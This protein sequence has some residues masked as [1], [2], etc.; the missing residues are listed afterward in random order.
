MPVSEFSKKT[1]PLIALMS[2]AWLPVQAESNAFKAISDAATLREV[3]T[4]TTPDAESGKDKAT[5]DG[6][7]LEIAPAELIAAVTP[8]A[9]SESNPDGV[10]VVA[11]T[12]VLL[13]GKGSAA[14]TLRTDGIGDLFGIGN[15]A[16]TFSNITFAGSGTG[17]DDADGRLAILA[18]AAVTVNGDTF[19]ADR[20]FSANEKTSNAASGGIFYSSNNFDLITLDASAGAISFSD[21]V[22][23]GDTLSITNAENGTTQ[24][25]K[26]AAAGGAIFLSG[27]LKVQGGNAVNFSG[28]SAES[29]D[30]NAFGGAVYVTSSETKKEDFGVFIGAGSQVN[31][32]DNRVLGESA[33]GGALILASGALKAEGSTLSFSGNVATA[34]TGAALGGAWVIADGSQARSDAATQ[35]SFKGN[36]VNTAGVCTLAAGGAVYLDNAT[37]KASA[38]S[39]SFENNGAQ[40]TADGTSAY[41]GALAVA[42]DSA[43]AEF[44]GDSASVFKFTGNSVSASGKSREKEVED[45]G[46]TSIVN[47]VPEALGG[48]LA[49]TGGK[50][51]FSELG[52][53]EFTRNTATVSV[54]ETRA[55][56]GAIY[57]GG[58]KS[59]L[60]FSATG[61]GTFSENAVNADGAGTAQGGALAQT[62]GTLK[63]TLSADWNFSGNSA[64]GIGST[65]YPVS[66]AGGAIAQLG[67][68]Q[69]YTATGDARLVFSA[70]AAEASS[71]TT[72][73]FALGGAI[74][75]L[76]KNAKWETSTAVTFSGNR[77]SVSQT[78]SSTVAEKASLAAGGAI[79]AMGSF[80]LADAVLTD[81]AAASAGGNG[82]AHGGAV[83]LS[84]ASFS[85]GNLSFENNAATATNAAGSAPLGSAR[86]GALYISS[87]T[88]TTQSLQF[89]NNN[90]NGEIARGGAAYVAGVLSVRKD[91][92]FSGNAVNGTAE[93][94]GGALFLTGSLKIAGEANF[95]GNAVTATGDDAL[96][97]GGAICASG[98]AEITGTQTTLSGNTVRA[99]AGTALGGAV[100]LKGGSL[101]L[102]N[103]TL[104]GNAATGAT[105]AGGAIYIDASGSATTLTLSGNTEIVGN[106][107][108]EAPDGITVGNGTAPEGSV[109]QNV[110]IKIAPGATFS[111]SVDAEGNTVTTRET[112]ETVKL[113][114]PLRVTLKGADFTLEKTE[115]GGD[116]IWSGEN[117]VTVETVSQ[118]SSEIGGKF[119]LAFRSGTTTLADGFMLTG[120]RAS[121]VDI[122]AGAEL[123]VES[124]A[125][126]CDFRSMNL[127][128]RLAVAGTLNLSD[129]EI[130][131]GTAG[132]F[133][134]EDGSASSVVGKNTVAGELTT[135]G[136]V[137]FTAN[138]PTGASLSMVSL[139]LEKSGNVSFS[140]GKESAPF[141]VTAGEIYFAE[142]GTLTLAEG[143]RLLLNAL[144]A[145]NPETSLS[146]AV[147]GSGTLVLLDK[148]D[149]NDTIAFNAY[150]DA[151]N[152]KVVA[153]QFSV[154]PEIKIEG[155]IFIA[156]GTSLDLGGLSY[157]NVVIDAGTLSASGTSADNPLVLKTISITSSAT[158][159]D[160]ESEQFIRLA[161]SVDDEGVA[162]PQKI[163]LKGDLKILAGTTLD[164]SVSLQNY[165]SANLSGEGT[166]Q[167][168]VSGPG[169]ISIARI[170][171]NVSVGATD[172]TTFSGTS[173][174]AGD[175]SNA[176]RL[177]LSQGAYLSAAGS[178]RNE[179]AGQI[180]FEGE[181]RFTGDITNAGK[182]T[183]TGNSVLESGSRF[184]QTDAGTLVV[185]PGASLD[186]SKI[187]S[188]AGALSLDGTLVITP[189]NYAIGEEFSALIGLK[190]GQLDA[191]EITDTASNSITDRIAWNDALDAYVFLGLNGRKI[192]TTLYGDL[193]RENIFRLYDFMRAGL[194]HGKTASIRPS[195]FG[196]DKKI[197]RY[198]RNYLE[199]KNRFNTADDKP[200]L[201]AVE[202]SSTGEA[203]RTANALMNNV[204]VQA[205]YGR[206]HAKTSEAHP[207]YGINAWGALLGTSL[208]VS[209]KSELGAVFGYNH[210]RMKH[211]G[212]NAHQIDVDAYELMGYYRHVGVDTDGTLALAGAYTSNASERGFA[213]A[214]FNSWQ[215]AFLAEGGITFRP[216]SWCEI[217]QF[218]ALRFAYSRTDSFRERGSAEAFSVDA[219]GSFA[220]RGTLGLE[221]A[222]LPA[223]SMQ[224]TLSA[225]LNQDMGDGIIRV[226]AFQDSTSSELSLTSREAKRSSVELGANLNYR[227]NSRLSLYTGLSA[228]LRSGHEERRADVGV[229]FTF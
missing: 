187:A 119:N 47:F 201:P 226:D 161:D 127:N 229:N 170:E 46:A 11:A 163:S 87:G 92:M 49:V 7:T 175:I 29:K 217:R 5:Y 112:F 147:E 43:V 16:Y 96:A 204:W 143:T 224:F 185:N 110:A 118:D 72:G 63:S 8:G 90:A 129:S 42:G 99:E 148:T 156:S 122:D 168:D 107:A 57:L 18:A 73:S 188:D 32:N 116:F 192:E 78:D 84:G 12:N 82:V 74:A 15:L 26:N 44:T 6:Y 3:L 215:V 153:S 1:F 203:A 182:L 10:I 172:R 108:N 55:L 199:R 205:Q 179:V 28:N 138:H 27:T 83:Y 97:L 38:S 167:G 75:Q 24:E 30:A 22:T 93:A 121:K 145:T 76:S 146:L 178:F 86:G 202:E 218:A 228:I 67:G 37:L 142:S 39:L 209:D 53:L 219:A 66:V 159:G 193:V 101:A 41:G 171:G 115:D 54:S 169:N 140:G 134:F 81:N 21:I 59:E 70:N 79:Y 131:L 80:V 117:S 164:A 177:T 68:T 69:S 191:L 211:S 222:F 210:S 14:T 180:I 65:I 33:Q 48:A 4:A 223:D 35:L 95:S 135:C 176:G 166:L 13:T 216:E 195:V 165:A 61:A 64:T 34:R 174:V 207:D 40:A 160:G 36:R 105:A 52:E 141:V 154:A 109:S 206:T 130:A 184:T 113:S 150:Y 85:A 125:T 2:A 45:N 31:F 152:K 208:A 124:G 214:D 106:S 62:A 190:N 25:S 194:L 225:A 133:V 162:T 186:F 60:S 58:D 94:S 157:E 136:N 88:A 103:A 20:F 189:E 139:N 227:V 9:A 221:A 200:S 220:A 23:Y 149:G 213:D 132:A 196:E 155:G 126:F 100:Y 89:N 51:S 181:T 111:S 144:T 212:A 91:V 102:K 123:K 173:F 137:A 114:D 158:F 197:S 151:E 120:T 98:V 104:S 56:G 50:L 17:A 128:G 19:F 198:M 183:L 77:V 71:Q